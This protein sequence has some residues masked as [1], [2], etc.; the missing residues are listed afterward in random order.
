MCRGRENPHVQP[1]IRRRWR[2]VTP[3][4]GFP[5]RLA[6]DGEYGYKWCKWLTEIEVVDHDFKGHYEGKRVWSDAATRGQPMQ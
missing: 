3:H 1:T 5:I 2:C 6:A 4:H